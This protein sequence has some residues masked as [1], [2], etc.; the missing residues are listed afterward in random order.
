MCINF[1][2]TCEYNERYYYNMKNEDGNNINNEKDLQKDTQ[3]DLSQGSVGGLIFKLALPT[4]ISQLVNMLYNIVDRIFIG[5]I[6]NDGVA[7]LTGLGLC[8]PIIMVVTAFSYLF[9]T[10]GAPRA[11]IEMGKGNNEKAEEILGNCTTA[12]IMIAI[13]LMILLRIF[14]EDLLYMFGASEDTIGFSLQYLNI[15]SLGTLSVQLALGLNSFITTQ[16]FAKYSMATVM[17]GAVTNIILDPIFIFGFDMGVQG[18][19]LA[20]IISQTVSALWVLKFLLGDK[21]VLKIKKENLKIKSEIILPVI[22]LGLAP[23]VMTSTESI[24]NICFNVSLQKYGGDIA[25]GSMTILSSIMSLSI[26]PLQGL[27]QGVQPIVSYNYGAGRI[28]RIKEAVKLQMIISVAFATISW[29]I[30]MFY[31]QMLISIFNNDESLVAETVKN[32]KVYAFGIFAM[33]V[34]ITCQQTFVALGKAKV[35]LLLACLRKII[36]LIPLI[37]LL[38][39]FFEDKV[40]AVFLAEPIADITASM[41]TFIVFVITFKKIISEQEK[42]SVNP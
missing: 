28:D 23:F 30:Q 42:G 3:Q 10:G 1:V 24:L 2:H 9:G 26:M 37:L 34:Q 31:P 22:A 36:I 19:A 8:F 33:G 7:A 16:G 13:L 17:I 39:N 29:I 35:A 25:V 6:P 41:T 15:Y 12:L 27:S 18:A 21:T 11:A 5:H 38:P 40:F 14:G 32:I 4:I 20:T